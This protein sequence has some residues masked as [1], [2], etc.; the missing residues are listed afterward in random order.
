M[1]QAAFRDKETVSATAD[2]VTD[3]KGGGV[4]GAGNRAGLPTDNGKGDPALDH[5]V[6]AAREEADDLVNAPPGPV[7]RALSKA[8]KLS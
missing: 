7:A 1:R 3:R 4:P 2:K 5:E 8:P 6:G